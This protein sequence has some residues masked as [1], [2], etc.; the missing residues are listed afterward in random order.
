MQQV[1][2]R[3]HRHE[4]LAQLLRGPRGRW[5]LGRIGVEDAPRADLHDHERVDR[6]ER[7]CG[8]DN[9]V[10]GDNGPSMV[11]H[12]RRP[13]LIRSSASST[14]SLRQVLANGPWTE[15]DAEFDLQLVGNALAAPRRI[16]C[17]YPANERTQSWR[18][19]WPSDGT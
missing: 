16:F 18:N 15:R 5:M 1:T 10:A 17:R 9:E 2:P 3:M 8:G 13:R 12:E 6:A 11:P 7:C 14:G 19:L 4:H